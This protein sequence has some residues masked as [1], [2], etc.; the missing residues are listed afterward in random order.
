METIVLKTEMPDIAFVKSGRVRDIYETDHHLLLIAT[1][2]IS[3]FDVVLPDGIPGKGRVLTQISRYW[4]EHMQDIVPNHLLTSEIKAFPET[5][6]HYADILEGRSMLVK[7]P[8]PVP[9]ECVVRG[10]L[11]GS[12]WKYYK[13]NKLSAEYACRK[14][15]LSHQGSMDRY[16][17]RA[18]RKNMG[19]I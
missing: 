19:M 7:K 12:G 14:V 18:R 8:K 17:L 4:F 2:R 5:L 15:S 10:Y 1:D 13:K 6:Q 3:A 11:S 16:S 9:I